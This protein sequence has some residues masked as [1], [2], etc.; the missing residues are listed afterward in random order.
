[1]IHGS[2]F[3]PATAIS[4]DQP[5]PALR[6][7]PLAEARGHRSTE[8]LPNCWSCADRV[9]CWQSVIRVGPFAREECEAGSPV[10]G[11]RPVRKTSELHAVVLDQLRDGVPLTVADLERRIYGRHIGGDS[12]RNALYTLMSRQQVRRAGHI[13]TAGH[14]KTTL[15]TLAES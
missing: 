15:W 9:T 12:V 13:K 4:D 6:R 3:K 1:M 5:D 7:S 2:R 11:R 14:D 10:N 8:S